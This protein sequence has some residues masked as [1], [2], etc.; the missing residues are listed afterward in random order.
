MRTVKTKV[1]NPFGLATIASTGQAESSSSP[2]R[3]NGSWSDP[4][5]SGKQG[6][7]GGIM[8]WRDARLQNLYNFAA[9][10]GEQPG[11][12]SPQTQAEF[13]LQ[14]DPRLIARLNAAKSVEE[15]QRLMN[16]AWRFAGYD[17]PGGEAARRTEQA[18]SLLQQFLSHGAADPFAPPANPP[19]PTP[20]PYR[21]PLVTTDERRQQ[22]A[23]S[24]AQ[25]GDDPFAPPGNVPI[26]T[27]RPASRNPRQ[28]MKQTREG[29]G[30]ALVR[31][32][33]ARQQSGLW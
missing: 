29:P 9:A 22:P 7:S 18:N 28:T 5:Q 26:P 30:A 33:L 13:F 2:K 11:A 21:D 16:N 6:T 31:A 14:E 32:L 25:P 4:S 12:I 19:V 8:S 1:S 20:R 3:A 15:A 27:P 23:M 10:R 24:P 17:Q